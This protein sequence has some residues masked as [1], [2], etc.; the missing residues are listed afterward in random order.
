MP[1]L[2][3]CADLDVVAPDR[4]WSGYTYC[5]AQNPSTLDHFD[6]VA[7]K[8][9]A[10]SVTEG[11]TL[12]KF[13]AANALRY[14]DGYMKRYDERVETAKRMLDGLRASGELDEIQY[15]RAHCYMGESYC[16][17]DG[18]VVTDKVTEYPA[19]YSRVAPA[20]IADEQKQNFGSFI[21]TYSHVT[22]LLRYLIGSQPTVDYTCLRSHHIQLS[23][24]D[25]GRFVATLETGRS[26]S[27]HWEEQIV[28][29]F[30]DGRLT[31]DML[32][33]LLRN[34]PARAAAARVSRGKGDHQ[35]GTWFP[36]NVG[37]LGR[38]KIKPRGS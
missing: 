24:L 12:V 19:N 28:V 26:S 11:R 37:G 17:A 4:L 13:A 22:N 20:W 35:H 1:R 5:L 38:S 2:R 23:V 34:T 16:N 18:H 21:N 30:A 7:E 8:P 14:G 31:L 25:Y 29:F 33:A 27:R 9:V 32:P 15:V 6:E 3:A 36:R 10:I